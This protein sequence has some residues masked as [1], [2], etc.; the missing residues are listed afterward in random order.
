MSIEN[1]DPVEL[2]DG[3]WYYWDEVWCDCYGPFATEEIAREELRQ[4]C[5]AEGL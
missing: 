1:A 2:I 3:L 5:V 4:Y